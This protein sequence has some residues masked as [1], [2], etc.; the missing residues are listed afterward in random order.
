LAPLSFVLLP[1]TSAQAGQKVAV[2]AAVKPD[3][4]SQPPGKLSVT[5]LAGDVISVNGAGP[6]VIRSQT[7]AD[8][9]TTQAAVAGKTWK[10]TVSSAR[11]AQRYP[12]H[13]GIQPT[14]RYPDEP[15]IKE[16]YYDGATTDLLLSGA[17]LVPIPRPEPP[18]IPPQRPPVI[19]VDT[20]CLQCGR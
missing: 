17:K 4:T 6:P 13:Y 5:R 1:S 7:M 2:A 11:K 9:N 10:K 18:F 12:F 3:A 19:G 16:L 20:N 15:F 14:G 8:V